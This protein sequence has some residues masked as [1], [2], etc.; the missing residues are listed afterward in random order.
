MSEYCFS[1]VLVSSLVA[2]AELISYSGGSEKGEKL[3]I[4]AIL[5]YLVICPLVPLLEGVRD[6]DISEITA[7][8]DELSGGAYLEVG[9]DAFTLGIKKLLYEKWG[10]SESETA[11]AVSGFDFEN[12]RAERIF[13]TLLSGGFAVD[14]REIEL[15]IERAGLGECE[16]TYAIK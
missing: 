16:V 11:V 4:S 2:F 7:G 10:L 9:E 15:Y 3:A 1:I 6:F 5:A 8:G 13:I 14:F 12:M